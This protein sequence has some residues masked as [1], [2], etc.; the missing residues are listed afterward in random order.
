MEW[1]AGGNISEGSMWVSNLEVGLWGPHSQLLM[2]SVGGGS[3]SIILTLASSVTLGKLYQLLKSQFLR[4]N[5][6]NKNTYGWAFPGRP[7]V[8]TPNSY[9]RG[10][11]FI[12]WLGNRSHTSCSM[13]Q[14]NNNKKS[15]MN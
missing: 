9:C 4:L 7:V 8:R 6:D 5:Y 10:P 11:R 12:L 1:M 2:L 3:W 13:R 14:E 15:L